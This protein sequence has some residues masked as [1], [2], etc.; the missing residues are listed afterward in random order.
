M[1]PECEKEA[2]QPKDVRIE[3][4]GIIVGT[5]GRV[6]LE[7]A[8]AMVV[9]YY[10][11]HNLRSFDVMV[12]GGELL[13]WANTDEHIQRWDENPFWRPDFVGLIKGGWTEGWELGSPNSLGRLNEKC[14]DA[15]RNQP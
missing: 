3:E 2:L 1:P 14:T 13:K 12:N 11:A 8:A 9:R 15:L 10:V 4:T 6:E 7:A 5:L